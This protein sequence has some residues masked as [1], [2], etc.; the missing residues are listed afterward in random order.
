M[1]YVFFSSKGCNYI[2]TSSKERKEN[3][4]E[5]NVR[6]REKYLNRPEEQLRQEGNRVK[7]IGKNEKIRVL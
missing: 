6:G 4:L 7:Y 2:D 1:L 3:S 5:Q